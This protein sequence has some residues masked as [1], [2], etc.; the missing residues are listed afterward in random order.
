MSF[1]LFPGV[2]LF[3][4]KTEGNANKVTPMAHALTLELQSGLNWG[5]KTENPVYLLA[6]GDAPAELQGLK[7]YTLEPLHPDANYTVGPNT[8]GIIESFHASLPYRGMAVLL[9]RQA[10]PIELEPVYQWK[11]NAKRWAKGPVMPTFI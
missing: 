6:R 10:K 3:G 9:N 7:D 5:I 4:K 1:Y 2:P 8:A 11:G